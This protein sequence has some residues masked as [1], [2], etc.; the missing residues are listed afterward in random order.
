MA[1]KD[2]E[3][4]EMDM[5]FNRHFESMRQEREFKP[6]LLYLDSLVQMG[7]ERNKA[8]KALK[9]VSNSSLDAAIAYIFDALQGESGDSLSS[10]DEAAAEPRR[11]FEAD[12]DEIKSE[13]EVAKSKPKQIKMVF[14]VNSSLK[15]NV[16]KV[17]AQVAHAAIDLFQVSNVKQTNKNLVWQQTGQTKIVLVGTDEH[18]L[19]ILEN[20]AKVAG[21]LTTIISDAGKTE[22][23]PGSQTV[24]GIF[25]VADEIDKI[26][27]HLKLL[28]E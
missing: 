6:N 7:I 16:G 19:Q 20:L 12:F 23:A 27:G 2:G 25:G 22:V 26:T 4:N 9:A 24:L 28:K 3:E 5:K 14:V 8:I 10:E 11:A 1:S 21:L 17:A 13:F 15:M 18:E